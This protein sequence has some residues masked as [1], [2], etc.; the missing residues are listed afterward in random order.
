MTAPAHPGWRR[1]GA[2]SNAEIFAVDDDII[3]IV[4]VPNS[5]DDERSARENLAFQGAY[6]R[7]V[8]RR[9][10][11]IVLMDN[12]LS[13]DSGARAVY[14]NESD[15]SITTCYALVGETF[16]G[17]AVSAVFEGLARPRV[18]TKIFRSLDEALTWVRSE[19]A[20][21]LAST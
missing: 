4:P 15:A 2:I 5:E 6:W 10:G 16:F 12:V 7:R 20:A 1:I 18:P 21:R 3:A 17:H 19:N 8:G 13:Q 11:A 9:G 14:A